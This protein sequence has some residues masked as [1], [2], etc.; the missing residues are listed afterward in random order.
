MPA[1]EP[2]EKILPEI[3]DPIRSAESIVRL[4]DHAIL[5]PTLTNAELMAQ[6]EEIA[7]YPVASVCVRPCDVETAVKVVAGKIAVGTVIGFPHG[8]AHSE[9]K[10]AEAERAFNSGAKD[11]DMVINVGRAL[12]GDWKYIERDIQEVF[13]VARSAKGILKVIF[14]TDL[15]PDDECKIRLCQICSDLSVDF[16]KTSTGFGFTKGL[17]GKYS[18]TGATEHDVALMRAHC[19]PKIG[20]KPSGGIR[21][22]DK[23]LRFIELGATRI[24]TASTPA[25]YKEAVERFGR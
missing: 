23:V 3:A 16:V 5:Q 11:V 19:P 10:A 22:L 25:I 2:Q 14:E 4:F 21:S 9:I 7:C 15:L 17:D 24:G 20:V 12:S 13:A 1:A 6:L 8:S 18:Y